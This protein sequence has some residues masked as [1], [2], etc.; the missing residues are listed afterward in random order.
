MQQAREANEAK[1]RFLANM[2]HEIR[3][4]MNAVIGLA[5]VLGKTPLDQDQTGLLTRI[6]VASKGL[7][8]IINDVLDLSKIEA[9]E[10]RL[11]AAPFDLDAVVR[12]VASL[13]SVAAED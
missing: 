9:G 8:S 12:D 7:L 11:E 3:T 13:I 5:H 1:S 10:M 2:S 6:K 4:P